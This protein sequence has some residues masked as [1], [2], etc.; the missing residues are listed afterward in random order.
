M[1]QVYRSTAKVFHDAKGAIT[2]YE[3]VQ[4]Q[5]LCRQV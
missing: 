3:V 1:A 2:V 5:Q 4:T